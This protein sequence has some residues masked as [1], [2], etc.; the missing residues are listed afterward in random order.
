M[1]TAGPTLWSRT[2]A[3]SRVAE[4]WLKRQ[5]S[6]APWLQW[7]RQSSLASWA[8]D[9]SIDILTLVDDNGR[10]SY[11]TPSVSRTL[12]YSPEQCVGKTWREFVHPDDLPL[13]QIAWDERDVHLIRPLTLE[14][15][16]RHQ[17]GYWVW[18]E[19]LV[20]PARH[21]QSGALGWLCQ[22]RDVS[23]RKE[24]DIQRARAHAR[25]AEQ[26]AVDSL[27]GLFNRRHVLIALHNECLRAVRNRQ[28]LCVLLIDIDH[29]KP[30]N[31]HYGHQTGDLRLKQVAGEISRSL[32]RPADIVGRYGG[33]EFLVVLPECDA[34]GMAI[35][36]EKIRSNIEGLG[37]VHASSPFGVITISVGGVYVAPG[38]GGNAND[39]IKLADEA[40]Y[41]AKR[42][43]RN[44]VVCSETN[45]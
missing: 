39:Y 36:A 31:D 5:A 3:L 1:T 28:S 41:Q 43:G 25:L 42:H 37:F 45:E 40:L 10:L 8:L 38:M 12:G 7:A 16:I 27:T 2:V 13:V 23:E 14:L 17:A 44:R 35:V 20:T 22:A 21:P 26:A 24:E 15:R 19:T 4:H 11:L 30:L 29:F 34:R 9:A 18:L 6:R 32:F 33:E